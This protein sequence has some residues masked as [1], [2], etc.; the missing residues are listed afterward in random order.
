MNKKFMNALL[1]SA[2]LLSAGVVTSCKDYDDDIDALRNQDETN[3][4]TLTEKLTAVE[5]S[6][7]NLQSAQ[8]S[9]QGDI[10]AAQA[11][12]DAAKAAGDEAKAAAEEAKKAAAEG[13]QAAIEEAAKNLEAAKAELT[14]LI[15][16][17]DKASEEAIAALEGRLTTCEGNVEALLAFQGQAQEAIDALEESYQALNNTVDGI[18]AK[19]DD[20]LNRVGKAETAITSQETA[21]A[22][23]K[24]TNDAAVEGIQTELGEL[25]AQVDKWKGLD[26]EQLEAM[27]GEIK[28]VQEDITALNAEIAKINENLATL[29]IAVYKGITHIEMVYG[30]QNGETGNTYASNELTLLSDIA[31]RSYTFGTNK[32]KHNGLN[33]KETMENAQEFKQGERRRLTETLL[34]RVTPADASLSAGD[35]SLVDTQGTDLIAEKYVEVVSVEKF[36]GTLTTRAAQNEN[37]LYEVKIQVGEKA[38]DTSFDFEKAFED[39]TT[40]NG[41]DVMFALGVNQAYNAL[42]GTSTENGVRKVTTSYELTFGENRKGEAGS[43]AFSVYETED[44]ARTTKS[45]DKI[46]NRWDGVTTEDEAPYEY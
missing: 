19:V 26:P 8:T 5:T 36:Q 21:L 28:K 18:N 11:A 9:L 42:P 13:Q 24:K 31:V 3:K 12:A 30:L 15:Q 2:A 44:P 10:D 14:E 16:A 4:A 17:G 7:A 41:H 6:I 43:I 25:K 27:E 29:Y 35:I 45:W 33:P 39:L 1:F 34:V 32:E 37:G 38:N 23:Y 20:L 40:L 46:A 22:E